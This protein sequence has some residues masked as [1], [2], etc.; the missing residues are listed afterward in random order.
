VTGLALALALFL[1]LLNGFFV[2]AEFALARARLTR[3]DQAREGGSATAALA[4][5]QAR[6]ID[7]YLAA[8]QLGITLASLGLGWVGEPVFAGVVKPLFETVGLADEAAAITAAVVAFAIIT[9]LHVVVG[10]LAPKS[11][12]IQRPEGTARG[13]AYGLE[14]FRRLFAPVIWAMNGLGNALVRL[15]G[16]RPASEHDAA[17]AE[18]LLLLIAES[19]RGGRLDPGEA[20]MLEGVF[21]LH[22]RWAAQVMT[23]RPLVASLRG[24]LPAGDALDTALET[25]HTRFPVVAAGQQVVGAVH[26]ADLARAARAGSGQRVD[27]L[28]RTAIVVPERRSLDEL[29]DDL[30]RA[31]SPLAVVVDEYGELAGV[32]TI[33][34]ILEE[35]VGEIADERDPTPDVERVDDETW[36]AAGHVSLGDLADLGIELV[37]ARVTSVGGLVLTELGRPAVAGDVVRRGDWQV[38]VRSV[39]GTRILQVELRRRE[40]PQPPAG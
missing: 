34:D 31:A 1:V 23:P 33:E 39:K 12:A 38:T 27:E 18:D 5:R 8:C 30:R 22:E 36:L 16:V 24:E 29:L 10:E 9:V 15:V 20:H 14:A 6:Q 25:P 40:P 32:L 4:A 35:I 7:R 37:D 19:E 17:T 2:A 26:L 28:M 3:L 13:L 21:D 11:I